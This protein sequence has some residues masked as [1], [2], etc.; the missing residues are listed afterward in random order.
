MIE[1]IF[2]ASQLRLVS[3]Q[4]HADAD[5]EVADEG[6]KPTGDEAR[7]APPEEADERASP[8]HLVAIE[9]LGEEADLERI[10][11]VKD[12][13]KRR[14]QEH[15]R[16]TDDAERHTERPLV[17]RTQRARHQAVGTRVPWSSVAWRSR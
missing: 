5:D 15:A 2:H 11:R 13:V 7:D 6:E 9:V 8:R 3:Q 17:G 12:H 16:S 1:K 14:D 4:H 10:G